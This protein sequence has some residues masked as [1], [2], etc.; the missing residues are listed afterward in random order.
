MKL[1]FKHGDKIIFFKKLD[2]NYCR[3]P[4]W[5]IGDKFTVKHCVKSEIKYIGYWVHI[6]ESGDA[7]SFLEVKKVKPSLKKILG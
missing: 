5:E 4:I 2:N 6:D 7:F 1:P 3:H